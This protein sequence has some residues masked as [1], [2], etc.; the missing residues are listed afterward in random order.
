MKL[1]E[2]IKETDALTYVNALK[3]TL[4]EIKDE[5]SQIDEQKEYITQGCERVKKLIRKADNQ[6]RVIAKYAQQGSGSF[7]GSISLEEPD[8]ELKNLMEGLENG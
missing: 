5:F 2:L 6:Y 7:T 4:T 8:Q 3:V 1:H